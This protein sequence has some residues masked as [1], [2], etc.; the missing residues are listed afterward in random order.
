ME[1]GSTVT[2]WATAAGLGATV[3]GVVVL[4][5]YA[6]SEVAAN[7]GLSLGD[8]YSI[9]RL[10]WTAIGVDALVIGSTVAVVF[11]TATV[12][13][14]G[15]AVRRV[16]SLLALAVAAF[17]WFIAILP[18]PGGA[19]CEA[20]A[21][22]GPDPLTYAYS[23]PQATLLLLVLPGAIAGALALTGP[24]RGRTSANTREIAK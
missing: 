9:G 17:W 15:P 10:P 20:C 21:P 16:V 18:Q 12:L 14:R 4:F 3:V 2:W 7:P 6:L 13:I 19:P 5:G 22:A 24:D 11:G 23:L 8:A 1:R